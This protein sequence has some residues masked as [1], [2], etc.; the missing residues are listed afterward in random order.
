MRKDVPH[1]LRS[2][3]TIPPRIMMVEE[4]TTTMLLVDPIRENGVMKPEKEIAGTITET[5]IVP[6]MTSIVLAH[7]IT[8]ALEQE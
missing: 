4:I 8:H 2:R 7:L 1:L 5:P 6:A 3:I